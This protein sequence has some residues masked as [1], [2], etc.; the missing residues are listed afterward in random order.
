MKHILIIEDEKS[1]SNYIKAT[2]LS[3]FSIN[4]LTIH[5][6]FTI[7]DAFAHIQSNPVD[8]VLLDLNLNEKDGFTLLKQLN[9][10][11][12]L[13]III[14]AYK[15]K[16]IEAFEYGV[17]DF[18]PKPFKEERLKQAFD[19]CTE[20]IPAPKT[21]YL[22]VKKANEYLLLPVSDIYFFEAADV[23]VEAKLRTGTSELLSVSMK[24]LEHILPTRF[25]RIHRSY[26]VDLND[27]R[28][29]FYVDGGTY[30]I[31]LKDGTVLPLNRAT[32]KRLKSDDYKAYLTLT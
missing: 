25:L 28:S 15:E 13:T 27:V 31:E 9:A 26:I 14:S 16:A 30:N 8:I 1:I 22:T 2:T 6:C 20:K 3:C 18:I 19:R 11:S 23:Y 21:K 29:F 4:E 7:E 24:K 12:F 10:Y 17:V 32:Y 5:Q